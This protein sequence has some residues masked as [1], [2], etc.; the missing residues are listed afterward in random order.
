MTDLL[1]QKAIK[2]KL[3]LT[4]VDGVLTDNG[5]YYSE[6]GEVMKRFSIR[7]GMGVE[8]LRKLCGIETG[9]VTGERS[10]SVAKRAE[11][12]NITSLHL[13]IKDKEALLESILAEKNLKAE[14]VAFIGDDVN[15]LGIMSKVGLTACPSNAMSQVTA[16][17]D[18]RCREKGGDGA[19]R[20][21]AE[22]LISC[23]M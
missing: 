11:K 4:D 2:I 17:A 12:L 8:R 7:D 5:V 20:D 1:R 16:V 15:D 3:L 13:G 6:A 23:R 14:E 9:I 22:W 10:P 19:F 21:F 18:Y